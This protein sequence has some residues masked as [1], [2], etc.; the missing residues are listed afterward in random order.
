MII[1][2]LVSI[3]PGLGLTMEVGIV[4]VAIVLSTINSVKLFVCWLLNAPATCECI[5]E[6][7]LHRQFYVLPH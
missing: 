4:A 7:D 5:S 1:I 6:T 2:K 3:Q